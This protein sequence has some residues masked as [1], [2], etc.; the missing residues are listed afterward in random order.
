M[1][2]IGWPDLFIITPSL[3]NFVSKLTHQ[4]YNERKILLLST[5]INDMERPTSFKVTNAFHKLT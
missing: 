4:I 3:F 5:S 1:G 2:K